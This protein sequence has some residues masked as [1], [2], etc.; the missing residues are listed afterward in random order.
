MIRNRI[1]GKGEYGTHLVPLIAAVMATKGDVLELGMGDFST[2]VLHEVLRNTTRQIFSIEN[3]GNWYVNFI[4][5]QSDNHSIVNAHYSHIVKINKVFSVILVDNA[6][7]EDRI[8]C[9][10][11][12]REKAEIFVV[13]DTDKMRYYGYEPIFE[14]F[15]YR[16]TYERYIKSTTLLSDTIDVTKII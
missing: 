14:T 13:H 11:E 12:F 2:P 6:P 10:A 3:D 9:L 5:L 8:K 15:R 16:N 4:D 7:A 1:I